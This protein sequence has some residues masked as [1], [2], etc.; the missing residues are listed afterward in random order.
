MTI[1]IYSEGQIVTYLNSGSLFYLAYSL[2]AFLFKGT[3]RCSKVHLILFPTLAQ[4]PA[5]SPNSA[6]IM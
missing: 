6:G 3:M 5:V 4:K 1:V 2:S